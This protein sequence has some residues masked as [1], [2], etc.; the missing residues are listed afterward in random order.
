MRRATII[1]KY[2]FADRPIERAKPFDKIYH[3]KG[4]RVPMMTG[5][6]A[7]RFSRGLFIDDNVPDFLSDIDK[8]DVTVNKL[9]EEYEQW[10][11]NHITVDIC[12]LTD[13][14]GEENA[15]WIATQHIQHI[16]SLDF[17]GTE[18]EKYGTTSL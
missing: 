4:Y 8:P 2:S 1:T 15:Q 6:M 10:K 13:E 7:T 16:P 12:A 5:Q 3:D 11:T 9:R 14:L 18:Y 17:T